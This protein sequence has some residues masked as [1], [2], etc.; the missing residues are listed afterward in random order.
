MFV[1]RVAEFKLRCPGGKKSKLYKRA[2]LEKYA[3]Y[4]MKDGLVCRLSVYDDNQRK[5]F[6]VTAYGGGLVNQLN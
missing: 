6:H 3:A 5:L 1:R 4:V 2:R